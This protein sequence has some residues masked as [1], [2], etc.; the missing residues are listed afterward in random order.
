MI[1]NDV[2]VYESSEE[3]AIKNWWL[4]DA[5]VNFPSDCCFAIFDEK[6]LLLTKAKGNFFNFTA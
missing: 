4:F 2:F 1:K 6:R 3:S 5:S